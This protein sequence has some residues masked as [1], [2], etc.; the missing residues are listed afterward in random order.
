MVEQ[1]QILKKILEKLSFV[2]LLILVTLARSRL[3]NSLFQS[4][5]FLLRHSHVHMFTDEVI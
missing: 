1:K 2:M 3:N 4:F 5:F